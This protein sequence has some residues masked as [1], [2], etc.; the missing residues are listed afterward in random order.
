MHKIDFKEILTFRTV[1]LFK[2]LKQLPKCC[3]FKLC[4][5][6]PSHS[7]LT[8]SN[9]YLGSLLG[10]INVQYAFKQKTYEYQYPKTTLSLDIDI[11]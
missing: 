8:A 7:P 11:L 3:C 2:N 5:I 6:P 9:N 4:R 10:R 1:E